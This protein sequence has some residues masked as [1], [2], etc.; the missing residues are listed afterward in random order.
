M[1]RSE[2]VELAEGGVL[3]VSRALDAG[4]PRRSLSRRL[5]EEGWSPI[6]AGVWGEPGLDLG[7]RVRLKA[8][9]SLEPRLVVSHRSATALWRI[10][11]RSG[12]VRGSAALEFVDPGLTLRRAGGGVRV[13][14]VP[15]APGDTTERQGLRV[16]TVAR[17]LADLLRAGPRDDALVA[18]E[19]ALSRRKVDH[20]RRAPL[21]TP[22]ALSAALEAPLLGAGRARRW[23]ELADPTSGSPAETIA[24]LR[25]Y[26]AGLHP[27][28][29]AELIT[30]GGRRRFLDFFF[31]AEGLAVEVEGYAYHG[32]RE[33]HRRDITRFNE[34]LQCP[35][36]RTLLRFTAEDIFHRPAH[37]IEEIRA[38]LA[39]LRGG[40]GQPNG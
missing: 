40:G 14:R 1:E 32:T 21:T 3:L 4:W 11:A 12:P 15:L 18:V 2:L 31:R 28:T 10:E 29:Q 37:M 6:R 23:L 35:E 5:R 25:M 38:A 13:H 27:E 30:P 9:Q 22:A 36:V 33:S 24:R 19:S 7:L 20:V 16:T 8:V 39:R 34:V 26:D 17:T